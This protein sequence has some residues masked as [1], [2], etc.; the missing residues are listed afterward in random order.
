MIF[1]HRMGYILIGLILVFLFLTSCRALHRKHLQEVKRSEKDSLSE[2]ITLKRDTS[3]FSFLWEHLDLELQSQTDSTGQSKPLFLTTLHQDNGTTLVVQ[4]GSLHLK[5]SFGQVSK[6][7]H[8]FH[9]NLVRHHNHLTLQYRQT[10]E[11]IQ[12]RTFPFAW[13]WLLL[14]CIGAGTWFALRRRFY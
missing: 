13:L 14:L 1:F 10:K 2:F 11:I 3:F 4:G 12:R 7:E 6:R 9:N 5:A 8:L